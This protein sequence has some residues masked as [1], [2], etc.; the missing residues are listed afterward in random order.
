LRSPVILSLSEIDK[1][2]VKEIRKALE[3]QNGKPFT[4]D[5]AIAFA[6]RAV[7]RSMMLQIAVG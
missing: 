1:S 4:E 6:I 7:H 3:K 2:K 5:D